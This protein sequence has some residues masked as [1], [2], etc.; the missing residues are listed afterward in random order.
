MTAEASVHLQKGF[1]TLQ[2]LFRKRKH[3]NFNSGI[4][5]GKTMKNGTFANYS[6]YSEMP[7]K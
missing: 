3:L 2:I 7:M 6:D 5:Q 4:L 1:K